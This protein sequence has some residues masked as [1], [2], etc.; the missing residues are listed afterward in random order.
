MLT[1]FEGNLDG[2]VTIAHELG[3]AYHGHLIQDHRP[4]N[5]TYTM[6]VAE[7]A[8]NFNETLVMNAAIARARGQEKLALLEQRLQDYTQVICDIYSRFLFEREVF[9]ERK[10]GFLFPER[11]CQIMAETQK[12]PTAPGWTPRASI[13]ICG[14]TRSTTITPH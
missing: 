4:L 12:R 11:L 6:P 14:S 3:H 5:R 9:E 7:T 1:N 13:P 10:G 8:S 2:V